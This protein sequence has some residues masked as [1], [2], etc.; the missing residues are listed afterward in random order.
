MTGAEDDIH[1]EMQVNQAVTDIAKALIIPTSSID[2]ISNLVLE[3]SKKLTDSRSGYVAT[4]DRYSGVVNAHSLS[5]RSSDKCSMAEGNA[6]PL[7]MGANGA[8]RGLWGYALSTKKSFYTN[9]P[10]SH[11]S[12][13]GLPGGRQGIERFLSVPALIGD[14]LMA[15]IALANREWDYTDKDI[16]VIER[17]S[18]LFA[19]AVRHKYFVEDLQERKNQIRAILNA[20]KNAVFILDREGKILDVNGTMT[21]RAGK[22]PAELLHTPVFELF[23]AGIISEKMA[24]EIRKGLA[25]NATRFEEEFRGNW[26][27]NNIFPLADMTGKTAMVAIYSHDITD[28]KKGEIALQQLNKDLMKEKETLSI[29]SSILDTMDDSV[30]FTSSDGEIRYVNQSF[31]KRMGYSPAEVEGKHVSEFQYPGD[32]FALSLTTF[33]NEKKTVW[34]GNLGLKNRYG[35]RIP[36]S[37]KSTPVVKDAWLAG[38]IFVFRELI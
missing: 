28:V 23:S 34:T 24:E 31:V 36:S 30:V 13:T 1:F 38:R 20:T 4:I 33:V 32:G 22:T 10:A 18:D 37:L 35:I 29:F 17:L 7:F 12:A 19:L 14:T 3:Y 21:D 11:P 9:A 6:Q 16:T 2:D 8:Y 26:F 5:N 25:G 15:Q 27:D